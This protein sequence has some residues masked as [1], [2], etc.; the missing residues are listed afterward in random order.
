[1]LFPSQSG[2][3]IINKKEEFMET[4]AVG[5]VPKIIIVTQDL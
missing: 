4:D 3:T 2:G 5:E 1:V